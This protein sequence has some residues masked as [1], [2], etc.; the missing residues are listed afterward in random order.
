MPAS[1]I[2]A[3]T[4]FNEAASR[5][6]WHEIEDGAVLQRDGVVAEIGPAAELIA[7]HPGVPVLGTGRQVLL[8]GFV[9]AHH[10]V[11]GATSRLGYCVGQL[12]RGST[13]STR[14]P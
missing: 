12:H 3:R 14:L 5:R 8:P 11:V 10:H 4:I 2:R 7:R 1:I 9:N 13:R 6:H